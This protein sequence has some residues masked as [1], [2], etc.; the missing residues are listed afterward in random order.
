MKLS[1]ISPLL[2]LSSETDLCLYLLREE[3][4]SWKFFNQL[5]QAGLDGSAYQTDLSMAILSLAGF[6][7]D[8]NDIHDFYYHL[9]DKLSTQMQNADEAVKYALVAYAELVN[10]R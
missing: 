10:R 7:E 5:R 4:K 1:N 8:S 3:I 9:I 2:P 6:S